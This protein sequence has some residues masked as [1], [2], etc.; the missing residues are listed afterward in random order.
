MMAK[1]KPYRFWTKKQCSLEAKKYKSR[2][3]FKE[4]SSAAY[5]TCTRNA[6]IDDVCKHMKPSTK[7][8]GYWTKE[9]C[10]KEALKYKTKVDF[11][12]KSQSAYMK[13]SRKGWVEDICGHMIEIKKPNGYWD[14]K[15]CGLEAKKYK[16]RNEFKFG[17]T[18]A[19]NSAKDNK[20]LDKIC[21]HMKVVGNKFKRAIYAF[22]FKNRSVYVGLT[23][24]YDRR[25]E[26]H[27]R[28]G[29]VAREL[30]KSPAVFVQFNNWAD[31]EVAVKNEAKK[32][33]EYRRKG[34]RILNIAKAGALGGTDIKWS[35]KELIAEARKYKTRTNFSKKS[36]AA[37]MAAWKKGILDKIC[38]HMIEVVKPVGYWTFDRI[39]KEAK[40]YKTKPDFKRGSPTQ[41]IWG[42]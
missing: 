28:K 34:W 41:S 20:W 27:M 15:R 17:N 5:S 3:E 30:E 14:L 11:L 4:K 22:E 25:Y 33:E 10:K 32:I 6:W 26:A 38:S 1:R 18:S 42:S 31:K 12:K 39:Y 29:P 9:Q 7:P 23:D 24:N 2:S 36:K 21:S 35:E 19:Y 37:Y 13:A 40:K 16:T 8:N